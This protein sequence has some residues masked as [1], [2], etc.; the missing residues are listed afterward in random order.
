VYAGFTLTQIGEAAI[1]PLL[2]V[3]ANHRG[4]GETVTGVIMGI[5]PIFNVAITIWMTKHLNNL[6]RKKIM[7][8]GNIMQCIGYIILACIT[9]I[10]NE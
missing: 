5:H 1:A 6:S 8:F 4:V 9:Y 3:E 2:P 10:P 7:G